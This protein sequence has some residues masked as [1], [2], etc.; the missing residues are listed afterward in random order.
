MKKAVAIINPILASTKYL[1][2]TLV[3][4]LAALLLGQFLLRSMNVD[5][6]VIDSL[7]QFVL[8]FIATAAFSMLFMRILNQKKQK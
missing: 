4:F 2:L 1:L 6:A 3:L 5:V 8:P 7:K